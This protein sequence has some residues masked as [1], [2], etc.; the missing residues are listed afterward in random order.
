M[1]H[2]VQQYDYDSFGNIKSTPFW[3]K[4]PY[5][6]TGR[7]FDYETG[8]YYYRAR[9]Y[10]PQVGRFITRDPI[11]F[12]GGIN[13]YV[14][15]RNNPINLIDPWGLWSENVH[16]DILE[17]IFSNCP[18]VLKAMI[19][20]SDFVD[21]LQSSKYS[22]LHSMRQSGDSV[23][24]A[25]TIIALLISGAR[26]QY[27]TT[28]NT[29]VIGQALHAIMDS[30]SSLH[31][32]QQTGEPLTFNPLSSDPINHYFSEGMEEYLPI[33]SEVMTRIK[34]LINIQLGNII[35]KICCPK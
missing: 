25:K 14:Y 34:L 23:D 33:K 15:T 3:I 19:N 5:T 13:Q 29:F 6:F 11:G 31:V 32:N 26:W 12:V 22:Y 10:D 21:T 30:T 17:E 24:D 1:G 28:G 9:Y 18:D 7:E 2:K 27:N 4:Q 20:A 8:L 35:D 16:H